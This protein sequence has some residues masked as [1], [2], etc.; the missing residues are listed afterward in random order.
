MGKWLPQNHVSTILMAIYPGSREYCTF[1]SHTMQ[2]SCELR[3][4][5]N[6]TSLSNL[7]LKLWYQVYLTQLYNICWGKLCRPVPTDDSDNQLHYSMQTSPSSGRPGNTYTSSST[8]KL[9]HGYM[10]FPELC[11]NGTD[12]YVFRSMLRLHELSHFICDSAWKGFLCWTNRFSFP[13]ATLYSN[14]ALSN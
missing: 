3:S 11:L 7:A 5:Q 12:G 10:A 9:K 1:N 8:V 14:R 6:N 13:L 2:T 4:G